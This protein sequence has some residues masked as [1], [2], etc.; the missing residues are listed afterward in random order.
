MPFKNLAD[1]R[2]NRLKNRERILAQK[3]EFYRRHKAIL[4]LKM[5]EYRESVKGKLS[6]LNNRE[7]RLRSLRKY[8]LNHLEI[9]RATNRKYYHD[10]KDKMLPA[11]REYNRLHRERKYVLRRDWA[12]NNPK[13]IRAYKANRKERFKKAGRLLKA[14]VQQ[15]YEANIKLYGTLTCYLCVKPILF[16]DDSLEH[17]IPL[18]RGG[19]NAFENLQVAHLRCNQLKH[20]KTEA[21]FRKGMKGESVCLSSNG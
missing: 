19:N 15:V 13:A 17:V 20:N 3:R 16:G 10:H 2:L 6:Y 8:R 9:R 14:Q 1:R 7:N 12:K 21:E 4:L 18:S 11:T 5:K